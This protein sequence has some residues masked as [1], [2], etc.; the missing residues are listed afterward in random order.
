V[1]KINKSEIS[2]SQ[3]KGEEIY[4]QFY[5]LLD[6]KIN[7]IY[8]LGAIISIKLYNTI[9]SKNKPAEKHSKAQNILTGK[10]SAIKS[11]Q[12]TPQKSIRLPILDFRFRFVYFTK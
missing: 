5:P 4:I 6:G 12:T 7:G 3:I 11:N 1:T 10:I 9:R 2:N 8:N